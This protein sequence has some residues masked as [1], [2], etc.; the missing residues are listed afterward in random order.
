MGASEC[1]PVNG[2]TA[3]GLADIKFQPLDLLSSVHS[4]CHRWIEQ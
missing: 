4:T 2:V 1:L 3:P